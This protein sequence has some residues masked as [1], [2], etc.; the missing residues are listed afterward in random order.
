MGMAYG[1]VSNKKPLN[2]G[3]ADYF[4]VVVNTAAR[5][6]ALANPGQVG[7]RVFS[8]WSLLHRIESQKGT[9]QGAMPERI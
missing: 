4:G 9:S 3:C 7:C 6:C 1:R 2:S 5:V 8:G